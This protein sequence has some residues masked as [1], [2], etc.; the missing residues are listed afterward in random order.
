MAGT[1]PPSLAIVTQF[2]QWSTPGGQRLQTC[3]RG[4][5]VPCSRGRQWLQQP[6]HLLAGPQFSHLLTSHCFLYLHPCETVPQWQMYNNLIHILT[7]VWF[8]QSHLQAPLLGNHISYTVDVSNVGCHCNS[9]FYFVQ[10]PGYDAG[11]VRRLLSKIPEKIIPPWVTDVK[12]KRRS[13]P[14]SFDHSQNVIAGPGG[15]YYCDANHVN[16]NW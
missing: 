6:L 14:Y 13:D 12:R 10:M 4:Q 11:Q 16:D 1:N 3:G 2:R 8:L 9:A 7:L 15:D 5:S